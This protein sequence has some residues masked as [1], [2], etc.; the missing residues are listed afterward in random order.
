MIVL[1]LTSGTWAFMNSHF[2]PR[3]EA[4]ENKAAILARWI[5]QNEEKIEQEHDKIIKIKYDSSLSPQAKE[6]LTGVR[7]REIARLEAQIDCWKNQ[8][9]MDC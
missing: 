8:K 3:V 4:G 1:S 5:K 2:M 7:I 9:R 6:E